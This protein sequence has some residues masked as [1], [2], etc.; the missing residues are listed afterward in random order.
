MWMN[1]ER[2]GILLVLCCRATEETGLLQ[3]K[4]IRKYLKRA[5]HRND[6]IN[7]E[8]LRGLV[9]EGLIGHPDHG[10]YCITDKGRDAVEK[11]PFRM[12]GT[13]QRSKCTSEV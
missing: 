1:E 7:D 4:D 10:F 6:S 8:G 3:R 9:R 5:G 13:L 12:F 2:W 11:L